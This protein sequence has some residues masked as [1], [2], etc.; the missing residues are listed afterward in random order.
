MVPPAYDKKMTYFKYVRRKK[1]LR[2]TTRHPTL[3][4]YYLLPAKPV[5][6]EEKISCLAKY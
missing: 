6:I 3:E 1:E 5:I 4:Y 2:A